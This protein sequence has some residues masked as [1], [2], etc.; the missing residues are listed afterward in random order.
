M[1]NKQTSNRQAGR[2]ADKKIQAK[3]RTSDNFGELHPEDSCLV[4]SR[5]SDGLHQL[6]LIGIL[7]Q[8][9]FSHLED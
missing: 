8:V 1:D 3:T 4:T 6:L 5:L 7:Q 9:V 2:Q